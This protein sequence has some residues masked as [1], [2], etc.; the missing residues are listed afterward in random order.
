MF[1]GDCVIFPS[2]YI[3]IDEMLLTFAF[4][5]AFG[6]NYIFVFT[7]QRSFFYLYF[8][9]VCC[10]FALALTQFPLYSN[11]S[12]HSI[13]LKVIVIPSVHRYTDS[14][15]ILSL[16][17][18]FAFSLFTVGLPVCLYFQLLVF[19]SLLFPCL[20][21]SVSPDRK[22]SLSISVIN[23]KYI[24]SMKLV[25]FIYNIPIHVK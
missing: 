17:N 24:P 23:S 18:S 6:E 20:D 19:L 2:G 9:L 1:N 4:E 3:S 11:A 15:Y 16:S 21:F 25:Y 5:V 12:K 10:V 8:A 7:F 22:K 14:F 13:T